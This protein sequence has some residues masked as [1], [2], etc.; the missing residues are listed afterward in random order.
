MQ[1]PNTLLVSEVS[2][3]AEWISFPG[4]LWTIINLTTVCLC[5]R[6]RAIHFATL[7]PQAS[8]CTL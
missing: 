7:R 1:I 2:W 3:S 8:C 5:R 6:N 4:R